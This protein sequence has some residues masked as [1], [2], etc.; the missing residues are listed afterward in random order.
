MKRH[1]LFFFVF[2]FFIN[3]KSQFFFI[4]ENNHIIKI[5]KTFS[6]WSELNSNEALD[7]F[8]ENEIQ[9]LNKTENKDT[10]II[11]GKFATNNLEIS[12]IIEL[13]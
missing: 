3:C 11:R 9:F 10:T 4:D 6:D 12:Y 2:I 13:I 7:Y 1:F 5:D 8:K